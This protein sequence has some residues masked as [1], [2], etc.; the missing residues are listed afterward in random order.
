MN[1]IFFSV[2]HLLVYQFFFHFWWKK[3]EKSLKKI[4]NK[5]HLS[6][7]E[8][9]IRNRL[10][11]KDKNRKLFGQQNAKII[12]ARQNLNLCSSNAHSCLFPFIVLFFFFT[13]IA[14]IIIVLSSCCFFLLFLIIYGFKYD[15]DHRFITLYM[16]AY[17]HTTKSSHV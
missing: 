10:N 14:I 17:I 9:K 5:I 1:P 12:H 8:E 3:G 7:K 13:I 16:K 11:K 2:V 4:L 6:K 15:L